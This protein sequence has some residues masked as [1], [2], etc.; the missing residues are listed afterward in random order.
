M[1]LAATWCP[2]ASREAPESRIWAI[3]GRS[4]PIWRIKRRLPGESAA[5]IPD[6]GPFALTLSPVTSQ[7]HDAPWQRPGLATEHAAEPAPGR[8]TAARLVDP[9]DDLTPVGYPGEFGTTAVIPYQDPSQAG[10]PGS[11]G[12]SL[13]DQQEPLPYVQPQSPARAAPIS[14]T[15]PAEIDKR[16]D[17]ERRRRTPRHPASRVVD[18]ARRARRGARCARPA[19]AVRLVGRSGADQL[20][21][22]TVRRRLPARR[23][24]RLRERRRRDRLGRAAGA[25]IV[26]PG[27][28]RGCA[29]VSDQRS[30]G[31]RLGQAAHLR[32]TSCR[33]GTNTR[34]P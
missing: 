30:A 25:G 12:Y 20:Q 19:E 27:G 5:Q 31:H 33:T 14:A 32:R 11:P 2:T 34:S 9:E 13:L 15:E 8:P 22:L 24:P 3:R 29:G 6:S 1:P 26:H 17:D 7:S 16:D 18:P 23:H 10:V 28:R 21:E 4:G